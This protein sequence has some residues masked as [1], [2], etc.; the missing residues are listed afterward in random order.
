MIPLLEQL[1]AGNHRLWDKNEWFE[2]TADFIINEIR[3]ICSQPNRFDHFKIQDI[4]DLVKNI[5]ETAEIDNRL[6][7]L[8]QIGLIFFKT[9]EY[10]LAEDYFKQ[11][12]NDTP[13]QHAE[14]ILF[15]GYAH[16]FLARIN[17]EKAEY[18]KSNLYFLNSYC[19][20]KD[21]DNPEELLY[22]FII[23]S[24]LF[25]ES[26]NET[27]SESILLEISSHMSPQTS[28]VYTKLVFV[29]FLLKKKTNQLDS[30]ITWINSLFSIP[31]E[32][33]E[34]D[35]WYSVH[36]F[37][38][39]Y[40]ANIKRNFE[41]SI[42]H[43]TYANTFLSLKW[44]VFLNEISRLK[45]YL[46]L[47]DYL[48]IRIAYEDKMQEIILENNLH[49]S[50]YL[51]SL[52]SAY[53][54]LEG[55]Y[56]KVHEMSLTDNLTGLYN[57]RYLWEKANEFVIMA[58]RQQVPVCAVMIDIDDFKK[59]NDGF[60]H[61]NGDEILKQVCQIIKNFF[62]KSDIVIR[63]GGEEIL[64]LLFN[65]NSTIGGKICSD[66]HRKIART[67]FK[68]VQGKII[69]ISVS[70]GVSCHEICAGKT[71][72]LIE[73]LIEEADMALYYSKANGKNQVSIYQE[74]K[75]NKEDKIE[76]ISEEENG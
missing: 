56:K 35:D 68:T 24:N 54:E 4:Y 52:K 5:P 63:F 26:G 47:S 62:R 9:K 36:L 39:E 61:I 41:K 2:Q 1:L 31:S 19:I 15:R 37:A 73:S 49:S 30:A 12:L 51:N 55:I 32:F 25:L 40:Y 70:I 45:D 64:T 57:R 48:K 46:K 11:I 27:L 28:D 42:Y 22:F 16:Y 8:M 67:Q 21:R 14:E 17:I 7:T 3:Q 50:H 59:V 76:F 23:W 74:I 20:L 33:L 6:L 65:S 60:G 72:K 10:Y 18:R 38:G 58:V 29:L 43:F 66:L 13:D 71:S 53:D 44:K 69:H 34:E 75:K